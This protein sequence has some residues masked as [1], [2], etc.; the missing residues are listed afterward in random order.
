MLEV[1]LCVLERIHLQRFPGVRGCSFYQLLKAL[2]PPAGACE[3]FCGVGGCGG[4][5]SH[6][7][8]SGTPLQAPHGWAAERARARVCV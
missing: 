6:G 5:S 4:T 1:G 7:D 3:L 2:R 8:L